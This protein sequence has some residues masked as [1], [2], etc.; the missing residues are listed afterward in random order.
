MDNFMIWVETYLTYENLVA[1]AN[2][3]ATVSIG[4]ALIYN[5]LQQTKM[6]LLKNTDIVNNVNKTIQPVLSRVVTQSLGKIEGD[7]QQLRA[8]N[9]KLLQATVLALTNDAE[10][11]LAA[12]KLLG[13]VE[14]MPQPVVV[15]AEQMVATQ[16][17]EQ[18]QAVEAEE[19]KTEKIDEQIDEIINTL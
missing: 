2:V 19:Q 9:R 1:A 10:S 16:I 18:K 5:K 8:E 3:I 13:E 6:T 17:E 15:K 14:N 7:M 11:R 4:A 12:I